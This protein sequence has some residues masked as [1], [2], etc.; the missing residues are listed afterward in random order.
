M[1]KIKAFPG[2]RP[3]PDQAKAVASKPYD[4][5]N[6]EEARAEA[7]DNPVS[8]LRVV[9]S[10]ITLPEGT[11]PYGPDVYQ[12]ARENF[13]QMM[14]DGVLIQDDTDHLYIYAQ[15]ME[16]YRQVGL[17]AASSIDDYFNDTIKKHEYT[18]P[19]KEQDRIDHMKTTGIHSGPVFLTFRDVDDINKLL[20]AQTKREPEYDFL[21]DDG[22][23]HTLWVISDNDLIDKLINLF[24]AEVPATYIAD[25]HHRAASSAKV[26]QAMRE[27]MGKYSGNEPFNYFLSVLFP[28]S[29]LN[30]IDYNRVVR[31]LNGLSDEGFLDSIQ[32]Q[33]YLWEHGKEPFQP[34][35]PMRFGM[36]FNGMWYILQAKK[37]TFDENDPVSSLDVSIL[38]KNLLDTILDI[39]DPR[40]DERIDFVGGIRGLKELEKRVD[41]GEMRVAFSLYPV[42]I[43]QLM[44]ISDEDMVMPPKSTWFEPKLRS[45][46]VVHQFKV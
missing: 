28:A 38:Q 45:G 46:L 7:K 5:L 23:R 24:A 10:E 40:T 44:R 19:K 43:E 33:F 35:R 32:N 29:Q 18:R 14:K 26:G 2:I 12:K 37:G 36:Y 3:R 34:E 4:V 1:V 22:V 42:S 20:E 27:E 41:S 21:A 17:V 30:I 15:E 25:G 11:D 13:Q 8:F 39:K 6:T 16:P 9:K 31:D